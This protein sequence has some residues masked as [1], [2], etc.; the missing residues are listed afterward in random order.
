MCMIP[1]CFN[2]DCARDEKNTREGASTKD[3]REYVKKFN[4]RVLTK[5]NF[6]TMLHLEMVLKFKIY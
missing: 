4:V 3:L 2:M 6:Y 1:V 5:Y